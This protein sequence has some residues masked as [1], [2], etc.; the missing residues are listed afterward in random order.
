MHVVPEEKTMN[1]NRAKKIAKRNDRTI[2]YN[3][4]CRLWEVK[5]DTVTIT[6]IPPKSLRNISEFALVNYILNQPA[7]KQ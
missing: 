7:P 1:I 2:Q 5:K 4:R 3:R 6:Y